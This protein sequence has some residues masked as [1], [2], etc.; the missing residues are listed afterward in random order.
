MF[1]WTRGNDSVK[2]LDTLRLAQY[3]VESYHT[4]VSEAV[5]ETG[6]VNHHTPETHMHTVRCNVTWWLLHKPDQSVSP[7]RPVSQV[8]A[9]LRPAQ[10]RALLHLGDLRSLHSAGGP[11]MGLFL[12]Q[13]VVCPSENMHRSE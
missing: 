2:G 5:Y 9:A 11:L 6:S 12:D 1:Y 7:S 13:P 10:E 4:T 3:S 8:G